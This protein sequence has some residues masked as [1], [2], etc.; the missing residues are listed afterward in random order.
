MRFQPIIPY[1][2][3]NRDF[4]DSFFEKIASMGIKIVIVES[5]KIQSLKELTSILQVNPEIYNRLAKASNWEK[6]H[7]SS[8]KRPHKYLLS[9][10]LKEIKEKARKYEL[11][12][13]TCREGLYHLDDLPI[14]CGL[15]L[16][17]HSLLRITLR[18]LR[19]YLNN[20]NPYQKAL[21][22]LAPH[23]YLDK[24]LDQ[25]PQ[26]LKTGLKSH[27]L[28]LKRIT[29]ELTSRELS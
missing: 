28:L 20:Q 17:E 24:K 1:V 3:A 26:P 29:T 16:M 5:I 12:I 10:I 23:K 18:E 6:I 14:C 21:K 11:K 27:I 13:V 15:N 25:I 19:P 2:N 9:K 7:K 8:L 4:V 22:I